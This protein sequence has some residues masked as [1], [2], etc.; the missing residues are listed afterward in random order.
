VRDP[1]LKRSGAVDGTNELAP[2]TLAA[3]SVS[4]ALCLRLLFLNL[5]LKQSLKHLIRAARG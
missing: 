3:W 4:E 2:D 5:A 1:Y